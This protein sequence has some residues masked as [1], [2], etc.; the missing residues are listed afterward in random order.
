MVS[1]KQKNI[2]LS[3]LPVHSTSTLFKT[4][5]GVNML[6]ALMLILIYNLFVYKADL[7]FFP[8]KTDVVFYTDQADQGNSSIDHTVNTDASVGLTCTLKKGFMFPYAGFELRVPQGGSLDLSMYDKVKVEVSSQNIQHL[9]MY[10]LFDDAALKNTQ[11]GLA[12]RRASADLALSRQ[13]EDMTLELSS[14][15]TPNWWYSLI[16]QPKTDFD[17]PRLNKFRGLIFSTG[18]NP[19]LDQAC[20]FTVHEITFH[21]DQRWAVL[22]LVAIQMLVTLATIYFYATQKNPSPKDSIAINVHYKA[23]EVP[24]QLDLGK[25]KFLTYIHQNFAN[26]ELTLGQISK[27]TGISEKTISQTIAERFDCNLKTY[28][29]K[30][31]IAESQRLLRESKLSISE[32]AYK[33]GFN[34]PANFNRVF[35]VH[36]ELSPSEYLQKYLS[37]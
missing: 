27:E 37:Q 1:T 28:I 8:N 30:I 21:K 4:A 12:L 24:E 7:S 23:V 33:T 6:V 16:G 25:E 11:H 26:A 10:L 15:T 36:T 13:T 5:I 31:R 34:S 2:N 14:F 18:V 19:V 22:L 9:S 20:S 29:N 32:I 17:T 35:K 3:P